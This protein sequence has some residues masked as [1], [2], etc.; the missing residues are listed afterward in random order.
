MSFL[1]RRCGIHLADKALSKTKRTNI[2]EPAETEK[3]TNHKT[4]TW[5]SV[6]AIFFNKTTLSTFN[7]RHSVVKMIWTGI[8]WKNF[9]QKTGSALD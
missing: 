7:L 8:P 3:G 6:A 4:I 1:I 9:V 2:W 5:V